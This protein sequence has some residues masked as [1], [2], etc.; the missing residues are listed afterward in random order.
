MLRSFVDI[1]GNIQY[2]PFGAY[3]N[4]VNS[5]FQLTRTI[6]NPVLLDIM[7]FPDQYFILIQLILMLIMI[8]NLEKKLLDIFMKN[9]QL[10]GYHILLSSYKNI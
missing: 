6:I 3:S 8:L 7:F 10:F 1:N 2:V 5:V 9:L 4:Q